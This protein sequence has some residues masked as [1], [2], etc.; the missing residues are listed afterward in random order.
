MNNLQLCTSER[1]AGAGSLHHG[2][3][4]TIYGNPGEVATK[5][6]RPETVT[7]I[8]VRAETAKE[9]CIDFLY[10]KKTNIFCILLYIYTYRLPSTG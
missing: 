8:G 9:R 10:I 1:G 3:V 4:H 2:L 5:H 6:Q 7:Y